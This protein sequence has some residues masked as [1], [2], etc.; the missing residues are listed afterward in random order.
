MNDRIDLDHVAEALTVAL[1]PIV[2]GGSPPGLTWGIDVDGE[3]RF[4]ALGHLDADGTQAATTDT[5]YRISSM[6]KPVTA[7]A[8]LALVEDGTLALDAPVDDL[9]PELA[10]RRVLLRPDGPIGETEAAQR[11]IT[12]EDLFSFRL[13]HGMDFTT[14]GSPTP[15]DTAMAEA[16][17]AAAPPAPQEHLPPDEWLALLGTFPLRHQPGE[18]WLYNTGAEV[19]GVLIAR[20]TGTSLG[21]VLTERV[22]GP[23]GM[24]DTGFSVP[25]EQSG[26]FGAC[27]WPP[28]PGTGTVAVYDSPDGQW[29][30]PPAFEGGDAGLVSTVGDYLTFGAMLRDGGAI[31]G[32]RVLLPGSIAAMTTNRLTQAQLAASSPSPDGTTGWGL[33]VGVA[34]VPT[35]SVVGNYGWD[36]GLGSAWR[37]DTVRGLSAVLLTNEAWAAPIPT[38]VIEAFWSVLAAE[39]PPV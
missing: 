17:L 32:T 1:S 4:G 22:F 39:V 29:A 7:V 26:R 14:M 11:P 38:T 5:I 15:L 6:T 19:L 37:N 33:G 3:R 23:L 10:E 28:D 31:G 24:R 13:G 36:G 8:A 27:F 9:L 35:L 30:A 16:G 20:A 21:A 25:A 34:L 12:V 18:R 2:E